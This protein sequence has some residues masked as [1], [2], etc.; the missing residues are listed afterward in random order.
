M[1]DGQKWVNFSGYGR[2]WVDSAGASLRLSDQGCGVDPLYSDILFGF[3][4][5][6]GLFVKMGLYSFHA[7]CVEVDGKGVLF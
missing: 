7:S 1:R 2:L 5:L 4:T 6:A 3:N